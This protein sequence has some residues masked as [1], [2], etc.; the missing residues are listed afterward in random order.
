MR[1]QNLL[2][3]CSKKLDSYKERQVKQQKLMI[4]K[5]ELKVHQKMKTMITT[6]QIRNKLLE[7]RILTTIED[8]KILQ[9]LW[10]L[11]AWIPK[12]IH[13]S[14]FNLHTKSTDKVLKSIIGIQWIS[15]HKMIK[16]LVFIFLDHQ[17]KILLECLLPLLE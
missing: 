4:W 8:L 11:L 12:F 13:Y 14:S 16:V 9:K 2:Q 1:K 10:L 15:N 5:E 6:M 3:T 7:L 17:S